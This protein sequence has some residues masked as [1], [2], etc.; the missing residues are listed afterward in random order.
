ML[1]KRTSHTVTSANRDR[2]E[3]ICA[4]VQTIIADV[5]RNRERLL[6]LLEEMH[7]GRLYKALGYSTFEA[8]CQARFQMSRSYAYRL[9]A[10]KEATQAA[11]PEPQNV[12]QG[13]K[14]HR[15]ERQMRRL[16]EPAEQMKSAPASHWISACPTSAVHIAALAFEA[17][18][19]E[20]PALNPALLVAVRR[21]LAALE[22]AE[23]A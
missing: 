20:R 22:S 2:G 23:S 6:A 18:L 15:S 16:R 13:D 11:L 10:F 1:P 9:L 5:K 4:E 21:F 8:L 17:A 19:A 7:R 12:A 3:A 14:M